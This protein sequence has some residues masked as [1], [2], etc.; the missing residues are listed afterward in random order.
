MTSCFA[1]DG[2]AWKA[3]GRAQ[4]LVGLG[5]TTPPLL[6]CMLTNP[7]NGSAPTHLATE[8]QHVKRIT[9]MVLYLSVLKPG[10]NTCRSS[11]IRR[12]VQQNERNKRLSSFKHR[13]PKSLNLINLKTVSNVKEN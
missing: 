10:S 4:A 2:R 11:N 12:V 3:D 6:M 1:V 8:T 5:L 9:N 13:V 7:N